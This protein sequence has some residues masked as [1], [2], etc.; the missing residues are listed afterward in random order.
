MGPLQGRV[1]GG[2]PA[3]RSIVSTD[4]VTTTCAGSPP[5][6][7]T[8]LDAISRRASSSRASARRCWGV[9][10]SSWPVGADSEEM[11]VLTRSPASWVSRPSTNTVPAPSDR[12]VRPRCSCARLVWRLAARWSSRWARARMCLRTDLASPRIAVRSS[13]SSA[14]GASSSTSAASAMAVACAIPIVPCSSSEWVWGSCSWRVWAVRTRRRASAGSLRS[15]S[16]NQC[17]TSRWPLSRCP[18]RC[19][20]ADVNRRTTDSMRPIC[21]SR[22]SMVR[23]RSAGVIPDRSN[24]LNASTRLSS[25]SSRSATEL[26]GDADSPR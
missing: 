23:P 17:W 22:C 10:V 6:G 18:D 9:R 26:G 13:A 16:W 12:S 25:S 15:R 24:A 21:W 3:R 11:A 1:A 19:A 20:N 2:A 5:S 4:A 8:R 14:A 7:G